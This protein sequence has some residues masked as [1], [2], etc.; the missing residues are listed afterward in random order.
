MEIGR[1][2]DKTADTRILCLD[3]SQ[4]GLTYEFQFRCQCEDKEKTWRNH[5]LTEVQN[6][7]LYSRFCI[8]SKVSETKEKMSTTFSITT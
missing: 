8:W 6:V 3:R 4:E 1:S 2:E 7:K 5:V